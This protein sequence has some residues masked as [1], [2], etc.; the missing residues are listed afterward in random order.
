MAEGSNTF[1]GHGVPLKPATG[2]EIAQQTASTAVDIETLTAASSGTGDFLVCQTSAGSEKF[3]VDK[4][5]NV[6]QSDTTIN[7]EAAASNPL[8]INHT[9]TPSGNS[10]TVNNS[11]GSRVFNVTPGGGIRTMVAF[12]TLAVAS[13]ESN[14]SAS[15]ALAGATTDDAVLML[16]LKT[17]AAASAAAYGGILSADKITLWA[18]GVKVGANTYVAW[19]WN[20]VA[21]SGTNG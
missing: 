5:G 2:F 21:N 19:L 20:T 18:P 1:Q 13:I 17:G 6:T 14:A 9:G 15:Y 11:A 4:D 16:P 8:T 10:I 7:A 12:S 3:V